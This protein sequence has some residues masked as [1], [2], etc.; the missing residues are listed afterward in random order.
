[1]SAMSTAMEST[2]RVAFAPA[3]GMAFWAPVPPSLPRSLSAEKYVDG[4]E[5]SA[6]GKIAPR[7]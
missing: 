6:S 7:S 1:M 3:M 5:A 2:P 4:R